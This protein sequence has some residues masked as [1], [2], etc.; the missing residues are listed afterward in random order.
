MRQASET[1]YVKKHSQR[2][3]A[4]NGREGAMYAEPVEFVSLTGEKLIGKVVINAKMFVGTIFWDAAT[5]KP[6]KF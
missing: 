3:M 1:T 2:F 4:K 6:I 5:K